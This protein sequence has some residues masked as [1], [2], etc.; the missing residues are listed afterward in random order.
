MLIPTVIEKTPQGERAYDIYSRLLKDNIIFLNG[1]VRHESAGLIIAQLLFLASED[2]KKE[3]KLYINSPGGVVTSGLAIYDTMQYIKCPITTLCIGQAASMGSLLLAGGSPGL[4][5]ALPN[6]KIM[7]HQ[8]S[9]GV[10][11]MASDINIQAQQIQRTKERLNLLYQ[12]HTGMDIKTIERVMDRCD[13][14]MFDNARQYW[15]S[16]LNCFLLSQGYISH[17]RRCENLRS[18]R[19]RDCYKRGFTETNSGFEIDIKY[20]RIEI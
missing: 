20:A 1:E 6:S 9:G 18:Y 7:L 5:Y 16:G 14:L 10:Q 8:P 3:I 12:F 4:R 11:G 17:G 15:T 13:M 2:P 19:P